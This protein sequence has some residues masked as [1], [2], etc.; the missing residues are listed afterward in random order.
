MMKKEEAGLDDD[1]Y[2]HESNVYAVIRVCLCFPMNHV[3]KG[4]KALMFR[5]HFFMSFHSFFI[6]L[7]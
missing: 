1:R 6:G 7:R 3:A 5:A 4:E 2:H